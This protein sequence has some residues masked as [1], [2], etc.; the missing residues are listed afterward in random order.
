MPEPIFLV[1]PTGHLVAGVP[2]TCTPPQ[3]HPDRAPRSA[4]R[5]THPD[6]VGLGLQS[7]LTGTKTKVTAKVAGGI[8]TVDFTANPIQV[9]GPDQTL[10][11]AQVVF[12]ATAAARRHRRG[13]PDRRQAHRGAHR[14]R[15][16]RSPVRSTAPSYQPQAPVH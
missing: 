7:F 2:A 3:R 1:A 5:R 15:G 6:R 9:V 13:L 8:A 4:P 14:Q 16:A 11:I 12:T 10:A